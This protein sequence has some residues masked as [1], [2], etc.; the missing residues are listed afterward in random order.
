MVFFLMRRRPPRS[1]RIDTLCPYTTLCRSP[2]G[3]R[4]AWRAA[5]CAC[6]LYDLGVFSAL[7]QAA[8]KRAAGRS[9]RPAHPLDAAALLCDHGLSPPDR[10]LSRRAARPADA[11]HPVRQFAADRDQLAR[12]Y[13]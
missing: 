2:H 10:G 12:L 9:A 4:S 11:A 3:G 1:T 5:L 7:L 8:R 13:L 6:R